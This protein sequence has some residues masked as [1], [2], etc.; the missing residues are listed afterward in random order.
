MPVS[1]QGVPEYGLPSFVCCESHEQYCVCKDPCEMPGSWFEVGSMYLGW[2]EWSLWN[3][4]CS[5]VDSPLRESLRDFLEQC[6]N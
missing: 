5:D 6:D 1:S 3:V 4:V 2:V